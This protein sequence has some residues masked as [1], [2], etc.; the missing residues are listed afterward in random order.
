VESISPAFGSPGQ[1]LQVTIKGKYFLKADGQLSGGNPNSGNVSLGSGITVTSYTIDTNDPVDNTITANIVIAGGASTGVRDV[2]VTSSF[3]YSNGN[4]TA[5]YL[6]GHGNFTVA[7][8]NATLQGDVSFISRGSVPDARWSEPVTVRCFEEGNLNNE[9]WSQTA[10]TD[11]N[12]TFTI[13]NLTPGTYDI[14]IKNWTCLSALNTSVTLTNN[15]TVV[16]DF[17]TTREGDSNDSDAVTI[18]DFSLLA[19]AF[20]S[21]PASGNWNQNCDFDRNGAVVILDFSLLAGNFGKA[22]PMQ[23][24]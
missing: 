18:I 2:N 15:S 22:G 1:S 16:V 20:G 3:G 23:G 4:G 11:N 6:S 13:T 21:T 8:A 24:Y 17:G 19:G 7:D 14:G 9:I 12:G 5:P 10:I